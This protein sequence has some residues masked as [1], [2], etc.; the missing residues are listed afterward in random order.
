MDSST[1]SSEQRLENI[2]PEN[3]MATDVP[4]AVLVAKTV[5]LE[6]P[7]NQSSGQGLLKA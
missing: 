3:M 7:I 5:N 4:S 6:A 1:I 2:Q